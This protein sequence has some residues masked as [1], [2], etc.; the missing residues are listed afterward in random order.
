MRSQPP[1]EYSLLSSL[2]F[3]IDW[4]RHLLRKKESFLQSAAHMYYDE[5]SLGPGGWLPLTEKLYKCEQKVDSLGLHFHTF[6]ISHPIFP[7]FL[8]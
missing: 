6:Q 1:V 3:E 4:H 5:K 7:A 8:P 2:Y